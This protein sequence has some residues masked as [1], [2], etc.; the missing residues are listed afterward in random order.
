MPRQTSPRFA[1]SVLLLLVSAAM[2]LAAAQ[3]RAQSCV[4]LSLEDEAAVRQ[5]HVNVVKRA[6]LFKLQLTEEPQ[7]PRGPV[8]VPEAL[9]E[10]YRAISAAQELVNR[11]RVG[12]GEQPEVP[13]QFVL[14][15]PQE[16]LRRSG[17]HGVFGERYKSCQLCVDDSA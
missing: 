14:L 1:P 3:V 13:P 8:V 4:D 16:V 15:Q 2:I 17:Y 6:I 7:N 9:Q 12:C 5:A 10:E 11:Q